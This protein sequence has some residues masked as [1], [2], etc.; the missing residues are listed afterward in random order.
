MKCE[1]V[2]GFD[3]NK[4]SDVEIS[5]VCLGMSLQDTSGVYKT[6]DVWPGSR[7]R[8]VRERTGRRLENKSEIAKVRV[9]DTQKS[10]AKLRYSQERKI[11]STGGNP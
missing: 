10:S 1:V 5:Q 6:S 9:I 4:G 2:V 7:A 11:G 8:A 3:S